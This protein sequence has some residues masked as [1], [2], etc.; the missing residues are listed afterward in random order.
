MPVLFVWNQAGA[1]GKEG[2]LGD[3]TGFFLSQ[4]KII[5]KVKK[6]VDKPFLFWY[7]N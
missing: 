5:K 3:F 4:Q 1:R 7:I 6:V 2:E